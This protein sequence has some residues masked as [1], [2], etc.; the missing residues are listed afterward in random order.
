VGPSGSGKSTLVKLLVGLYLPKEGE[1]LFND[2]PLNNLRLNHIRR[3]LGFVTQDTQ[4]FSGTIKENL[5][6]VKSDATDEEIIQA[7]QQASADSF[8]KRA[9]KGIYYNRGKRIKTFRRGKTKDIH[10]QGFV[11]KPRNDDI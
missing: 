10:C 7:L 11:K 2:I 5:Q 6:L 4:L 3:Q 1:I 8:L 9:P